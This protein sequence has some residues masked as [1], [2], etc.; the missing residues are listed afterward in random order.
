M[1]PTKLPFISEIKTIHTKE[2]LMEFKA[3]KPALQKINLKHRRGR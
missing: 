2:K 1:H 3:T